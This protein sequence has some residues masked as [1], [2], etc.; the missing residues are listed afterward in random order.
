MTPT[1]IIIGS[2]GSVMAGRAMS[3]D[4]SES[5]FFREVDIEV[6]LFEVLLLPV[7]RENNNNFKTA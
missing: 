4:Y 3:L 6:R 5:D 2:L 7:V 1:D